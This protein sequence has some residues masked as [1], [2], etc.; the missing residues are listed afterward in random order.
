MC[1]YSHYEYLATIA[2][3]CICYLYSIRKQ[4]TH[5]ARNSQ[6]RSLAPRTQAD[7][8]APRIDV[9]PPS[10]PLALEG[11]GKKKTKSIRKR[12]KSFFEKDEKVSKKMGKLLE[13]R[14]LI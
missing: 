7:R 14:E 13:R 4:A 1:H 9:Y 10:G 3:V 5:A 8:A 2:L 6:L 11:D 12:C